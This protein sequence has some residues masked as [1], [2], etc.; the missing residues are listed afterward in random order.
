VAQKLTFAYDRAAD[1]LTIQ[2]IR[3]YP[4]QESEEIADEVSARLNPT[5]GDVEGLEILF[6]SSRLLRGDQFDLP[7]VADLHLAEGD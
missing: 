6:F 4:E 3:P 7:V 2:T 1:S 5:T